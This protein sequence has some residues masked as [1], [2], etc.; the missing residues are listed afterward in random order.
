MLITKLADKRNFNELSRY[1]VK[2]GYYLGL[3]EL[4]ATKDYT[5][6]LRPI[7]INNDE[8]HQGQ[9]IAEFHIVNFAK[10]NADLFKNIKLAIKEHEQIQKQFN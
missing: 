9:T 8:Q 4:P 2:K 5:F 1:C 6:V 3:Q 10:E 7:L